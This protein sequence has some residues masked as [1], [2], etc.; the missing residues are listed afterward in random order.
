MQKGLHYCLSQNLRLVCR[1]APRR[2]GAGQSKR[3]GSN[4][5]A[6][7]ARSANHDKLSVT[8]FQYV[9]LALDR[10]L[11]LALL[12]LQDRLLPRSLLER[13][14]ITLHASILVYD[15]GWATTRS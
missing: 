14:S 5:V 6:R 3:S 9:V 13:R 11:I 2:I 4:Y 1:A 10:E 15:S 12:V 7:V 8:A